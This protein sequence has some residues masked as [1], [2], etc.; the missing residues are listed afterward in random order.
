MY[1][2][3]VKIFGKR[4]QSKGVTLEEAI[5]NLSIPNAR[6]VSVWTVRNGDTVR[7]KVVSNSITSRL[8]NSHGMMKDIALKQIKTL[9]E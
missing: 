2:I 5:S 7:E 6:G 3:N 1:E 8:F 4:W 9:F